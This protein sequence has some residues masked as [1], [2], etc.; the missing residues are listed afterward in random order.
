MYRKEYSVVSLLKYILIFV[1]IISVLFVNETNQRYAIAFFEILIILIFVYAIINVNVE[2]GPFILLVSML[3]FL[4]IKAVFSFWESFNVG[5]IIDFVLT[6]KSIYYLMLLIPIA[7]L[8]ILDSSMARFLFYFISVCFFLKYSALHLEGNTRPLL[9]TENNFEI[10]FY[11]FIYYSYYLSS[12][13]VYNWY[14]IFG[15][16]LITML[17]GSRSGL[18]C[19]VFLYFA[20][21]FKKLDLKFVLSA[22]TGCFL[23]LFVSVVFYER[24]GDSSI[25]NIDRVVFFNLWLT[26][27]SSVDLVEKLFGFFNLHPLSQATCNY[28]N[29]YHLLFS[30]EDSSMCYSVILHSY[31]LRAML[32]YGLLGTI[33]VYTT[34]YHIVKYRRTK[35]DATIVT[36]IFVLNGMSVSAL[37]STIIIFGLILIL[38]N[39]DSLK[40]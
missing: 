26:E 8:K 27:W 19:F 9:F 11:L 31:N 29:Y 22:V 37:S 10:I 25:S 2:Y 3:T 12:N 34:L 18:A 15:V 23:L 4:V 30:H 21:S 40:D 32:D 24:L 6:N 33:F 13:R 36:I 16:F 5:R 35:R 1:S 20:I 14:D 38:L 39:K 17:T 28:L 7:R